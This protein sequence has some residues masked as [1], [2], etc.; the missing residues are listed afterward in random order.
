VQKKFGE[1][2]IVIFLSYKK[3]IPVDLGCLGMSNYKKQR[4]ASHHFDPTE[5]SDCKVTKY[6]I[7][8]CN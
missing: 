7:Q 1:A 8:N 3:L 4:A 2:E 6:K 5:E